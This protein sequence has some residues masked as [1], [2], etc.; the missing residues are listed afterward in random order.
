MFASLHKPATLQ[1]KMTYEPSTMSTTE[2][3]YTMHVD[4]FHICTRT[5]E[6][7]S[8]RNLNFGQTRR[9]VQNIK[10]NQIC[11]AYCFLGG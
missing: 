8:G 6:L 3:A 5:S 10:I 2:T 4:K 9:Y 1:V 7:D 11:Q